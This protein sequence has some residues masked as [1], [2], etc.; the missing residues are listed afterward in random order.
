MYGVE[1]ILRFLNSGT[2]MRCG[3]LD[4]HDA[5]NGEASNSSSSTDNRRLIARLIGRVGIT[6][7]TEKVEVEKKDVQSPHSL[8]RGC[9]PFNRKLARM[10]L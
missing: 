6:A 4:S 8:S 7:R 1:D 10:I 9:L 3:W 5:P 2:A